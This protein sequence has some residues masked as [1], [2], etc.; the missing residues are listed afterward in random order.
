MPVPVNELLSGSRESRLE[1]NIATFVDLLRREGLPLGTTEMMDALH[2]LERVD[3]ASRSEFKAALQATLIKSY[4]DRAL[5]NRLFEAFFVPPAEYRKRAAKSASYREQLESQINRA[6]SELQFKGESLQL[7]SGELQQYSALSRQ[8]RDRL[9]DFLQKT[10][11]GK[12]VESGFRPLLET[13]V[14]SH[15][16]YCRSRQSASP[17][18]A[19]DGTGSGAGTGPGSENPDL[20]EMDIEAIK[21]ADM[22]AAGQLLQKL[23]QKLAVKILRRRRSGPRSGTLDLR[24]SM[25]D[26]MRFGGIIFNLKY[27]PRRRSRQQILLLCDVSASMKQ[28][29]TF[30]MHFLSGLREVVL[31]LSCFSF[32]DSIENLTPGL[33][34]RSDLQFVL[35]RV[36]RQSKNWGGGTNLGASLAELSRKYPDLVNAKTT[37]IVVSDTK[38]I[39]INQALDELDK[40]TER[41]RRVIWLNPLPACHWQDYRSVS[42]IGGMVEMWPCNTIAQLEEV[43]TGRL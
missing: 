41:V 12:N 31:N 2:A 13:V 4:R 26:N 40:L 43:L 39:A 23:S 1:E 5:F 17:G 42:E 19:A 6:D 21:A 9:Q 28:Y 20:R 8:Q 22:P 29:S 18:Q 25:R 33:K 37:V 34:G 36:V 38:T 35:D 11:T 30:V 7:S 3:L 10:E 15:L 24:R 27:K 32:S 16:R 14:K